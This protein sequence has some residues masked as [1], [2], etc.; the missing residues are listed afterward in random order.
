ME[1]SKNKSIYIQIA[2]YFYEHI[3]LEKWKTD[4][5]VPSVRQLAVDLEV[6]PNTVMRTYTM[7]QDKE[8]IYNQR[9]KGFF[10]AD[11]AKL[12]VA[13]LVKEQFVTNELPETFK[14]MDLLGISFEELQEYHKNWKLN[15]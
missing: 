2:D 5:K 3:L 15:L 7:L 9:G 14:I 11:K 1:F 13:N 8:I 6:N 4:E 12:L 10:V